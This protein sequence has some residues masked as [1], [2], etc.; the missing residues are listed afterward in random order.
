MTS[1]DSINSTAIRAALVATGDTYATKVGTYEHP[2]H[3]WQSQV[4]GGLP[5]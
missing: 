4:A 2:Q 5:C 1:I 3:A